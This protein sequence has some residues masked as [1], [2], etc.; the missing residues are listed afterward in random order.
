MSA[1]PK[2]L[3]SVGIWSEEKLQLLRCYLGGPH[4]KGGFLPATQ[5]ARRRFYV[6]LFAGPG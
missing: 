1:D 4:N 2:R 5:K 3:A 6:D